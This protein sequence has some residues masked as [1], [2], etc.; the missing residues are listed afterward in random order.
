[1]MMMLSV[2]LTVD[3]SVSVHPLTWLIPRSVYSSNEQKHAFVIV[4][5]LQSSIGITLRVRL[6]VLVLFC[7]VPWRYVGPIHLLSSRPLISRPCK[8]VQF[9][10]RRV[11]LSSSWSS[12]QRLVRTSRLSHLTTHITQHSTAHRASCVT[13]H[14]GS[15]LASLHNDVHIQPNI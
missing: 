7:P 11:T 12:I 9:H 8:F 13:Q 5:Q 10:G 1:M 4:L 2:A 14:E 15:P 3:L 6:L